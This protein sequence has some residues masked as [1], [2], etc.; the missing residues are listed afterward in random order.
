[1]SHGIHNLLPLQHRTWRRIEKEILNVRKK[2]LVCGGGGGADTTCKTESEGHKT[3]TH[4]HALA[5]FI[6]SLSAPV[7][8]TSVWVNLGLNSGK[9]PSM[10]S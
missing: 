4:T 2:T 8:F 5:V 7:I 6:L 10:G 9:P 3:H 1:M